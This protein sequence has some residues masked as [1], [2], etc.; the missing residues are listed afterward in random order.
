MSILHGLHRFWTTTGASRLCQIAAVRIG[1]AQLIWRGSATGRAR[2]QPS[3]AKNVSSEPAR[4]RPR[5]A[6][7]GDLASRPQSCLEILEAR[8]AP[9]LI[10]AQWIGGSG[11]WT[12]PT[13]WDIGV[14]PN[15]GGGNTYNAII[16]LTLDPV[17][18]VDQNI[19][20][21]GLTNAESVT[22]TAGTLAFASTLA[23]RGLID[24]NGTG[25]L[26][27][28]GSFTTADLG[29]IS[30]GGGGTV[31]IL[32]TLD[33][34]N[35]TLAFNVVTGSWQLTGGTIKAGT[36][37]GSGGGASLSLPAFAAGT[38]DGVTLATD[39]TVHNG[40]DLTVRNGLVLNNANLILASDGNSTRVDF[41]GTQSLSGTGE[42]ILGGT[43]T[44]NVLAV[45][46]GGAAATAAT[47]TIGSGITVHGAQGGSVDGAS[48]FDAVINQG[49]IEAVTGGRT[50]TLQV[51]NLTNQ[52]TLSAPVGTLT[53]KSTNW[54]NP[55][56]TLV[57]SGTGV[58]NLDGNFTTAAIGN[59]NRTGGTINIVGTLDNTG[60]TLAL[61]AVTGSWQLLSGGTIKGGTIT[62]AGGASLSLPAFNTGTL[63]GVTLASDV[64][65]RN[66][67]V[68]TAR[69]GLVLNNG[70][71]ILA[72]DGN[73][74]RVDF[75]GHKA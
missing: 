4:A 41:S 18:T 52:G 73:S 72:S 63:D 31:S 26:N 40:G 10:V 11:K 22:I 15:N 58:L 27:L 16:D 39:V 5:L 47:L 3:S 7:A 25:K 48:I 32:G 57:V 67:A 59:I 34:T 8:I 17:V 64:T 30:S 44:A 12:D 19:T 45:R 38:F 2:V 50:V 20:V 49:T 56:G 46:G 13:H 23:N 42:V 35:G 24:V 14:V 65:M 51:D 71:L 1:F 75:S 74:T 70:K 68:L 28:G 61:N 69:N 60:A 29:S 21:S 43:A 53:I 62:G 33:N 55:S 36:I 37:A 54:S 9:A 6:R 66:G